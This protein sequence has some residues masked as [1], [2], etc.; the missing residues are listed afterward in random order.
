[1]QQKDRAEKFNPQREDSRVR[2]QRETAEKLA[3]RGLYSFNKPKDVSGNLTEL[4]SVDSKTEAAEVVYNQIADFFFDKVS[5]ISFPFTQVTNSAGKY[6]STTL[7][8]GE[9]RLT[10][11]AEGRFLA[12]GKQSRM[13][14]QFYLQN[15]DALI[16]YIL[17]PV[18]YDSFASINTFS[19]M[20]IFRS[21]LGLKFDKGI[22][23][24]VVKEA[25]GSEQSYPT[26]IS[27]KGA[28]STDTVVLEI[29]YNGR[30]SEVYLNSVSLGTFNTDFTTGFTTTKTFLSLLAPAIS[31]DGTGVNI[32]IKN[33]QYLQI[34]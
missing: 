19:S 28:G 34:R 8:G 15:P 5:I 21:Y 14:C 32:I 30:W 7:Y 31:T 25:G 16:G 1:M 12:P 26:S 20:S 9:S 22:V 29:M 11:T 3:R 33:F 27:F 18:I 17:S 23:A 2:Q 13:K 6:T 10:D 4:S 24:V